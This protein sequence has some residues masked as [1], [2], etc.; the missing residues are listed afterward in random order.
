MCLTRTSRS[1][2]NRAAIAAVAVLAPLAL[3][4]CSS[5]GSG[6][7]GTGDGPGYVDSKKTTAID[8]YPASSRKPA[9]KLSGETLQKKPLDVADYKGKV[10]V[11]NVWGSWCSPCRLEAKNLVKVSKDTAKDGVV[12][13][14]INIRDPDPANA[15]AFERNHG[16]DYPSIYDPSGKLLVG[17][18]GTVPPQTIPTT[19]VLDRQGKI[20]AR[21]LEPLSEKNLRDM[22]APVLAEKAKTVS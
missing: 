21:A 4:A 8:Q 7:G 12:F 14:G 22:L 10:V 13:V 6:G 2:R 17:F 20:A 18:R 15:V 11:L 16:V 19:L 3:A 9:P 5:S 1:R